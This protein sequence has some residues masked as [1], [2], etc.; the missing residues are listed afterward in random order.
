[1]PL[2][3]IIISA[4]NH[5]NYVKECILSLIAQSYQKIELIILD[6]GSSDK[7]PLMIEE[8]V[9]SCQDRFER[10]IFIKK[11]NEGII[12][13][14]IKG[15][16]LA[17]GK[18]LYSLASDD[19]AKSNAL[20]IMVH[21]LENNRDFG[22]VTGDNDLIDNQ[23]N[24]CFW[25]KQRSIVYNEKEAFYSSFGKYLQDIRPDVLFTSDV[26]GSYSSLL[27]GNYIPNG[28]LFR[29]STFL[30]FGGLSA[31]APL[32]DLHLMLQLSKISKL[33]Y[34]EQTVMSYRWHDMNAIKQTS[35]VIR[36]TKATLWLESEYACSNGH[37]LTFYTVYITLLYMQF[38][39]FCTRLVGRN[40]R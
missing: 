9:H 27:K 20:E 1:M 7:T 2:V 32:E 24:Q 18:Y 29:H 17:N 16:S 34:I 14:L 26:F 5:E 13:T 19:I 11:T 8:M 36:N 37:R 4:F 39:G 12:K 33:K 31:Q 40:E 15:F 6:D 10:F 25:S 38:M 28:G 3:S 21:F 35:K 30:R 23:G 22:Y